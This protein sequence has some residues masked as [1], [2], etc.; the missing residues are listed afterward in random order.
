MTRRAKQFTLCARRH[1]IPA[2]LENF[3]VY[4]HFIN[5]PRHH[6]GDKFF[7]RCYMPL[8]PLDVFA[9]GFVREKIFKMPRFKIRSS[10][11]RKVVKPIPDKLIK[12][13]RKNL[14]L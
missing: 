4:P 12:L 3:R 7:Q 13:R 1:D 9:L 10:Y 11:V 5:G 14:N 2:K 8:K 6:F